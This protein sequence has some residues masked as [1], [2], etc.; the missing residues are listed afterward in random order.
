MKRQCSSYLQLIFIL[1]G[2]CLFSLQAQASL[3][4]A[5][6]VASV[7]K[8]FPTLKAQQDLIEEARALATSNRGVFDPRL[9]GRSYA[10]PEGGYQREYFDVALEV[11]IEDSAVK[12]YTGYRIGRGNWP[13]YY[14]EDLTNRDGE[15]RLGLSLPLLRDFTLD[16][17]RLKLYQSEL[18]ITKKKLTKELMQVKVIEEARLNYWEWVRLSKLLN[19]NNMQL[20]IAKERQKALEHQ[21]RLGDLERIKLVEN[22]QQ[23]LL[24]E[25]LVQQTKRELEKAAVNLSL[26]YRDA[27]GKPIVLRQQESSKT[28]KALNQYTLKTNNLSYLYSYHPELKL[29][30]VHRRQLLLALKYAYN[31]LKPEFNLNLYTEQ[32]Y[33]EGTPALG[34]RSYNIGLH[35]QIPLRQRKAKG[36]IKAAKDS[37]NA[38]AHNERFIK[39]TL[40]NKTNALLLDL[41]KNAVS[42]SLEQEQAIVSKRVLDAEVEKFNAG[43]S[44][45][46]LVNQ[47]E[48]KYAEEQRD[49]VNSMVDYYEIKN[50]LEAACFYQPQCFRT[51]FR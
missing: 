13:V 40:Y 32:D 10:Q 7:K 9:I 26:Y 45:L 21:E 29:I 12:L 31:A 5:E 39:D 3:T 1:L 50:T 4:E 19:I 17:K 51:L 28:N 37:L 44:S 8:N 27:N 42:Y 22:K 11:P 14:Q 35:Y 20:S 47:R 46:F 6:L 25:N 48:Q 41:S 30:N 2:C 36:M 34:V 49:I 16:D 18:E 15:W 24:R 38:L 33:G 23:I 43:T